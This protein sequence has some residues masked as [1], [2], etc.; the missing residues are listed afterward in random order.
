[1]QTYPKV[2]KGNII[3]DIMTITKKVIS[4]TIDEDVKIKIKAYSKKENV[5]LSAMINKFL[6]RKL[7]KRVKKEVKKLWNQIWTHI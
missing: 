5:N 7:E 4:F 3:N 6:K 2:Y 1:M